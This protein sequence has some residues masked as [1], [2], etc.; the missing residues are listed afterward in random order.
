MPSHSNP[1]RP[2]DTVVPSELKYALL[3]IRLGSS[4]GSVGREVHSLN[5]IVGIN[6]Y[7]TLINK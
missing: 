7:V 1:F 4:G 2:S 3:C 6:G 5:P